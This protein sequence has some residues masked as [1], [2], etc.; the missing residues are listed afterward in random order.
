MRLKLICC[1]SVSLIAMLASTAAAQ[2]AA[3][4]E[5][6]GE[7]PAQQTTPRSA[8]AA[9][10]A[11]S[12]E[13]EQQAGTIVVTGFRQSLS[14]AQ[15]LKRTSDSIVDAVVSEEIGKL[16]DNNA[17]EALSRIP[18]VQV[19]WNN[20][21]AGDQVLIRGLPNVTSTYNSRELFSTDDRLLHFQDFPSS[22]AAGIEVYKSGTADLIEPGLG[23]LINLRSHRPFDMQDVNIAGEVKATYNDQSKAIEPAG[24]LLLAKTW[25]TSIGEIGA[26]LGGSYIR[27]NYRN[28]LRFDGATIIKNTGGDCN[29]Q[30]TLGA[31]EF[32]YPDYIGNFYST[33]TRVRPS[34]NGMVEWRPAPNLEFYAEGL[35]SAYRGKVVNDSFGMSLRGGSLSNVVLVEGEEGKAASLTHSGGNSPSIERQGM[36]DRTDLYQGAAGFE[37]TAGPAV[38]S[39]DVAYT[40]SRYAWKRSHVGA[41][42]TSTPTINADFDVDGSGVFDL[43]GY[44]IEDPDNYFWNGLWQSDL[45]AKGDGWQGRLDLDYDTEI[46]WL[47][48]LQFGVRGTT[49]TSVVHYGD[50]YAWTNMA[51]IPLADLPTGEL[52]VVEDGW[53]GDPQRLQNWLAP[54]GG[55]IINNFEVLRQTALDTIQQLRTDLPADH[56]AQGWFAETAALYSTPDIQYSPTSEFLGKEK[57]YAGYAQGSYRFDLGTVRVDGSIG[58]RLVQTDG[59]SHGISRV[60]TGGTIEFIPRTAHQDW[61]D[62]L[63]SFQSRIRFTDEL[64]LRLAYTHTRSRPTYGQLN[65]GLNITRSTSTGSNYNGFGSSGNPDL[66]PLTSKNYDASLEYYF[67]KNGSASVAVFYRDLWGFID[68][69]TTDVMDPEYGLIQVT[70]P[71][72]AGKGEIKGVEANFQTFF[73]FLPG[74]LSGFGV[75]ANVTYLDAKN[76]LPAAFGGEAEMVPMTNASKW[77]YNL[78]A[79]YEKGPISARLSYNRR[80]GYV[81][82]YFR[83][84]SQEQYAGQLSRPYARLDASMS[85]QLDDSVSVVGTVSNILAQGW[86]NYRYYNESQYFPD[87]MGVDGRYFSLGARFKL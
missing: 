66:E 81:T 23:G 18:G 80:S 36:R 4:S 55:A 46:D 71:E 47:P 43:D 29:A 15:E 67:S 41:E 33:G 87:A 56:W 13:P 52:E 77:T 19:R 6:E 78:S 32:C 65:P 68:T 35:W 3:T 83:N 75:Q 62:V 40:K 2:E 38:L 76:A 74:W 26:L 27:T 31:G 53:R 60:N 16:P 59:T 69:Y 50:R 45:V 34:V 1:A 39:G 73:N 61:F 24:N 5:Q 72:N 58:L 82:R 86:S 9:D 70:R 14:S 84:I 48:R 11:Q 30:T 7:T 8:D 57:T 63:P 10:A 12:D 49:R 21:E 42:L 28:A 44:D 79:F 20:D 37:W 22:I 51:R 64:Q 25:D 17:A 85:Y 54:N